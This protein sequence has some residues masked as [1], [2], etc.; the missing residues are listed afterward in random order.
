MIVMPMFVQWDSESGAAK[1][2]GGRVQKPSAKPHCGKAPN[3]VAVKGGQKLKAYLKAGKATPSVTGVR[4]GFFAKSRYPDGTP[5]TNVAAWNEFG[6]KGS[7]KLVTIRSRGKV[8][9]FKSGGIPKRP[10][11]RYA[12]RTGPSEGS[13]APAEAREGEDD[14]R[15]RSGTP[16][17]SGS[18]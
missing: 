17:S 14:E 16:A 12:N 7:N 4:V 9:R 1:I 15:H 2:G 10:F 5:V 6:T 18:L 8:F 11:M 3:V 13:E